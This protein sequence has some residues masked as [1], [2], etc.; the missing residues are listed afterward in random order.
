[1]NTPRTEAAAR[2]IDG[3]AD[4]WVP[5]YVSEELERELKE[6]NDYADRLV[7][8]KDMVCLPADLANLRKANTH[9]AIENEALKAQQDLLIEA[10]EKALNAT[11][12]NHRRDRW[13]TDAE[14]ALHKIKLNKL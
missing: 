12:L 6:A 3:F 5:Q 11:V 13:H 9:F 4:K 10:L 8:H 7:E 1:M 2:H 14:Y